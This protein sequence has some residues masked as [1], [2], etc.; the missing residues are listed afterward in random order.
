MWTLS[1]IHGIFLLTL[2]TEVEQPLE[3][4]IC[5]PAPKQFFPVATSRAGGFS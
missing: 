3:P 4:D 5:P 1:I 2:T